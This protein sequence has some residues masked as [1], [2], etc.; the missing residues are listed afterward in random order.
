MKPTLWALIFAASPAFATPED[1]TRLHKAIDATT[2]VVKASFSA[3]QMQGN[4]LKNAASMDHD[5]RAAIDVHMQRMAH[6]TSADG[7]DVDCGAPIK[8]AQ[9]VYD[10]LGVIQN[11]ELQAIPVCAN[12]DTAASAK[13]YAAANAIFDARTKLAKGPAHDLVTALNRAA[14]ECR[15]AADV[16]Y[17][18]DA[19]N[20]PCA[21]HS[22]ICRAL[23]LIAD[24]N[25]IRTAWSDNVYKMTGKDLLASMA[26]RAVGP[27]RDSDNNFRGLGQNPGGG[28]DRSL[29]KAV[30]SAEVGLVTL[31]AVDK[32]YCTGNG[33][34]VAP[35]PPPPPP[36]GTST[37]DGP[38]SGGTG[39]T[40]P[41]P[42]TLP[43][44]GNK[45][46]CSDGCPLA[47]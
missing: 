2:K 15:E 24:A 30:A 19:L 5:D 45:Q 18:H 37:A 23:P 11:Q 41:Q 7:T 12:Y 47:Q 16:S 8:A 44:P 27:L 43:G 39:G 13:C 33:A 3:N 14:P 34:V 1:C 32:A 6:Q 38:V 26:Q 36:V 4:Y 42:T 46:D 22:V 31:N 21:A 10:A 9:A 17:V 29:F 20:N 28:L 35:P 25:L 40:R